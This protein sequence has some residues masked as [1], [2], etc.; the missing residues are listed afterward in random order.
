MSDLNAKLKDPTL[1]ELLFIL[2]MFCI[3]QE[4][5]GLVGCSD[6][7]ISS[8]CERARAMA[9]TAGLILE[10]WRQLSGVG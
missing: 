6:D 3:F 5:P 1:Q 4:Q 2:S 8:A 9:G 7:R 10:Q